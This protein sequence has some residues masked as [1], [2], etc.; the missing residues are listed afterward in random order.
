MEAF[1]VTK[2]EADALALVERWSALAR[3][4]GERIALDGL[5]AS[6]KETA[7][8]EAFAADLPMR[9]RGDF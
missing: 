1:T 4:K 2:T 9:A 6:N 3:K 8:R 7:A 5:T